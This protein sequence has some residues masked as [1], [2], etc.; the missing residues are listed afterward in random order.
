MSSRDRIVEG[1][2]KLLEEQYFESVGERDTDEY[3]RLN[4]SEQRVILKAFLQKLTVGSQ[5]DQW[6][7]ML[8]D[9]L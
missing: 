5:A 8:Q 4:D 6:A 1:V 3:G 2:R 9:M 7:K